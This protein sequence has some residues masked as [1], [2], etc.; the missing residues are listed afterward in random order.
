MRDSPSDLSSR[1][2]SSTDVG[3]VNVCKSFGGTDVVRDLS[4]TINRGEFF[5]LLGPSGCGKTTTLRMIAG[6]EQPTGG[7]IYLRGKYINDVPPHKRATNMVFQQMALFPHLSVFNNVAFGLR[8]KK[9]SGKDIEHRVAE[10]LSLVSL[11]GFHQR[12]PSQLSGGQQQRVAIAR[13]LINEPAVLLLDEPLGALDLKLRSQMQIELKA[14]QARLGTTFVYVT[15]DQGE[16]MAMS[17]RI[18]LMNGGKIEQLGSPRDIYEHPQT[19]FVATFVGDTNLLK[20]RVKGR[21]GQ[22]LII[23]AEGM[24]IKALVEENTHSGA[25][26][27]AIRPEHIRVGKVVESLPNRFVARIET[28]TYLG[29]FIRFNL[30]AAG[31]CTL[32]AN[33]VNE[34]ETVSLKSGDE[35]MMAWSPERVVILPK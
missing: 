3:L 20:G 19:K 17:D 11:E 7:Q 27:I 23:D 16:A 21:E 5:S 35:I 12:F 8:L 2:D 28:V 9:V 31:G 30:R 22:F 29:T 1:F 26:L 18:A 24:A 6:F 25:T 13:A 34:S 4:L 15:H 32:I 33:A 10:A 14:L